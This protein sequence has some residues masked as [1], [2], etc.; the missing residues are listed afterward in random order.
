MKS[1]PLPF[2][3]SVLLLGAVQATGALIITE[4]ADGNR[5]ASDGSAGVSPDPFLAFVELTNTGPGT[6][7]LTAFDIINFNNGGSTASFS[8]TTLTGS[9]TAGSTYYFAYESEPGVGETSAFERTYGFAPNQFAGSKFINGDDVILLLDTPYAG[10]GVAVDT[11]TIVDTYGVLGVDGS[12]E[13]WE[14]LDT[15]A[16]RNPSVTT[17]TSTF[18]PSEWTFNATNNFDGADAAAHAAQTSV[19]PEPSIALLGGLGLLGLIRRRRA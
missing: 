9:L 13:V 12:G 17:G 4:I 2:I 16:S 14:Y 15:S 11:G 3:G 6:V 5:I 1:S 18:N 7:D 19:V 10:G 8:S